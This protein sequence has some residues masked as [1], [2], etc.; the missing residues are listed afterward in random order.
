MANVLV[1]GGTRFFGK[2][3]VKK[4]LSSGHHV[5][6]GSRGNV[7]PDFPGEVEY[8]RLDRHDVA[9]MSAAIN[10]TKWDVVY[11]QLCMDS[12]DAEHA[13]QVFGANLYYWLVRLIQLLTNQLRAESNKL[14]ERHQ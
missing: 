5:C 11:D 12:A 14:S 13:I 6:I 10:G 1:I 4:L 8:L 9:S 3:I 2:V 7:R